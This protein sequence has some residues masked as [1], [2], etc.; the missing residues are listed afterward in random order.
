MLIRRVS[1]TLHWSTMASNRRRN[2][3]D[4]PPRSDDESDEDFDMRASNPSSNK[5]KAKT[6]GRSTGAGLK[7]QR[8][9]EYESDDIEDES[10][11]ELSS[12]ESEEEP[13][14]VLN[15]KTGRPVRRSVNKAAHYEELS[16]SEQNEDSGEDI[17]A[18]KKKARSE[19]RR[20]MPSL[21]VKLKLPPTAAPTGTRGT[22]ARTTSK[23]IVA[24]PEQLGTRRSSRHKSHE[25]SAP[26]MPL[27]TSGRATR[28]TRSSV[29]QS[30]APYER[31]TRGSKGVRKPSTSDILE[32][33][34]EDSGQGGLVLLESDVLGVDEN[35]NVSQ[36]WNFLLP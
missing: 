16:N 4:A 34:Q 3:R 32:V 35:L 2:T 7:R 29:S 5:R 23:G 20:P 19:A 24:P 13:F 21:V 36:K 22:R 28:T 8:R 11:E 17:N 15:E 12:E 27:Q 14:D 1:F 18:R 10:D 6:Q 33:S 26:M 30:P 25:D 9:G 31:R